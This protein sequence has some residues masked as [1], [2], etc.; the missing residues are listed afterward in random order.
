[1]TQVQRSAL[2]ITCAAWI[3]LS[4]STSG[5]VT[6]TGLKY[7]IVVEGEGSIAAV[8]DSVRV[9]ESARLEDGTLLYSTRTNNRPVVFLLG[10]DQ[11]I[12]GVN[13]GVTGRRVGE[14]RKLVV[15]PS[16][17]K[18]SE[19]PKNIPKDATLYYNIELLEI[20]GQS[21]PGD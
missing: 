1:M 11:V 17:S 3:F 12:D 8:G 18:R 2:V 6:S 16:L 4:C 9:H 14:R 20:L 19:Y 7:E 10:G 21:V 13:E 5:I 15:P